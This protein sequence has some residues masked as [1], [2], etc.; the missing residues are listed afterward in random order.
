MMTVYSRCVQAVLVQAQEE[1]RRRGHRL[2]GPEHL[3]LA[4]TAPDAFTAPP[5]IPVAAVRD[6]R[7][8]RA[9]VALGVDLD[10][11]YAELERTV[12]AEGP[13]RAPIEYTASAKAIVLERAVEAARA[14]RRPAHTGFRHPVVGAEHLLLALCTEPETRE[15]L[16]GAGADEGSVRRAIAATPAEP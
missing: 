15:V 5:P 7:A 8:C 10:A 16:A 9:L 2:A 4:L 11:L 12:T 13:A 14:V 6:G 1:A 3:L